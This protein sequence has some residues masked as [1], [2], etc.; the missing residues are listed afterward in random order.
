MATTK[1]IVFLLSIL[2][3]T[4]SCNKSE[5]API[6]DGVNE[7]H[8]IPE[9]IELAYNSKSKSD[10]AKICNVL[11]DSLFSLKETLCTCFAISVTP[12]ENNASWA[13]I[14]N[15]PCP[16]LSN[17]RFV[18]DI[19]VEAKD[20]ILIENERKSISCINSSLNDFTSTFE[21]ESNCFIKTNVEY[22]GEVKIQKVAIRLSMK[23]RECK[24]TSIDKWETFFMVMHSILN[25]YENRRDD[26]SYK[27]WG[28]DFYSLNYKQK[29][30]VL[31]MT[32]LNFQIMFD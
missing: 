19:I 25:I 18:F 3:I 6:I 14:S 13:L 1:T 26:I 15:P 27:K 8:S 22:F 7:E 30:A 17:D 10:F 20:S 28:V 11:S 9:L 23:S 12:E 32:G 29:T 4:A 5:K 24:K 16:K 2:F 31:K 21:N